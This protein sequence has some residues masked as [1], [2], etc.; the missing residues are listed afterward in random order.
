M[1][2]KIQNCI[3]EITPIARELDYDVVTQYCNATRILYQV[4]PILVAVNFFHISDVIDI[5]DTI[6]HYDAQGYFL[7]V[8]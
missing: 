8:D 2:D 1:S 3:K 4:L 5:R 6:E 7:A